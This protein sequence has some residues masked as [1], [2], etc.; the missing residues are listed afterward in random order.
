MSKLQRYICTTSY[1]EATMEKSDTFGEWVREDDVAELERECERLRQENQQ[2]RE[3]LNEWR[4]NH[5]AA[6]LSQD[7]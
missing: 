7:D 1:G 5:G 2:L 3:A 6:P 4:V